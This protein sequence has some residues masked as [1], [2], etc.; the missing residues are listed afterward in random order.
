M[1]RRI[2]TKEETGQL[3]KGRQEHTNVNLMCL[4]KVKEIIYLE[5]YVVTGKI[6]EKSVDNP[7]KNLE[8]M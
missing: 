4:V 7:I 2:T 1:P 8:K 6:I 5:D 3:T